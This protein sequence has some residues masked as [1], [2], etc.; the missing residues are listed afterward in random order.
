MNTCR[1]TLFL[2]NFL[3]IWLSIAG[4]Y[5]GLKA[6][7]R[8]VLQGVATV[9]AARLLV[10]VGADRIAYNVTDDPFNGAQSLREMLNKAPLVTVDAEGNV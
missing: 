10:C 8:I 5:F 3:I 4:N 2:R 6:Q 1:L 7:E 9:T